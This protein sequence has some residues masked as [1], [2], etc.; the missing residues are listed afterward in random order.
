[1]VPS[2]GVSSFTQLAPAVYSVAAVFIWG[3]SDFAGGYASKRANAF[4]FTAF[5]HICAFALMLVIALAQHGAFPDRTSIAWALAAGVSGGFSL[6]IFYRALAAGQMGLTAPHRSPARRRNPHHGGHRPRRRSQPMVHRRLRAR[7]PGDLADHSSRASGTKRRS[8]SPKGGRCS[9]VGRNRIRR[10]LPLRPPGKRLC[11]LDRCDHPH[12]IFCCHCRGGRSDSCSDQTRPP[13]ACSWNARWFFRHHRKHA[14]YLCQPA[15]PPRR[16]G[17]HHVV[18]SR[19]DSVVSSADTER[20][21]QPLEI[22]RPF[23]GSGSGSAN[24]CRLA[25]RWMPAPRKLPRQQN[26]YDLGRALR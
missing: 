16:G 9:R 14:L 23:G 22:C 12:R 19:G 2:S 18:I 24:F 7:G 1:M 20:T 15:R 8:W 13:S 11:Q 6:A 21:L 25:F 10:L 4:V 26:P 3:T 17:G 5:S